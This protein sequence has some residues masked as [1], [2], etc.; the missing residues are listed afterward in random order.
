[1]L[2]RFAHLLVLVAFASPSANAS[3]QE[4]ARVEVRHRYDIPADCRGITMTMKHD[5][6]GRSFLYV[7]SKDA[8][9]KIYDV[10]A[11]PALVKTIPVTSFD[12][13]DVMNVSQTDRY[14]YLALGEHFG[15]TGEHPGFAIVDVENPARAEVVAVWSDAALSG[16]A[17]VVECVGDVV[18]LGAMKNGLMMFDVSDRRR[19]VL[20][21][22]FV[23]DIAYPDSRPD[24]SK[25]N[26]R[27]LTIRNDLVYLSYDA[28]G[29]R[30]IDVADK[31]R[32][33][34]VGRFS[35]PKM[36]RK[37]RGLQQRRARWRFTVR[38]R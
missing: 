29:L 24:P 21:S 26:A 5:T 30:I 17:G 20:L 1:M 33:V 35:N 32:P 37:P 27:G 3:A 15:R 14:L 11:A 9:L 28:G 38:R 16:G 7:A 10:S 19:I 4:C 13:L 25:Y 23:P 12:S 18:Y 34:E 36:N 22:R 2:L 8:G 6:R 31:R